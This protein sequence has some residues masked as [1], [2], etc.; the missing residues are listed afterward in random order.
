MLTQQF[1]DLINKIKNMQHPTTFDLA[2]M[3]ITENVKAEHQAHIDQIIRDM[4]GAK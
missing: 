2:V 1:K 4:N 3:Q